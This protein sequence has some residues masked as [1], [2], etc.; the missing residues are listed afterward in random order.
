MKAR[1]EQQS[2]LFFV[3]GFHLLF[4]VLLRSLASRAGIWTV[5]GFVVEEEPT[6]LGA[7]GRV[8]AIAIECDVVEDV[9]RYGDYS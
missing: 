3:F 9:S 7:T 1:R 2:G 8:G 4:L 6:A 5:Q